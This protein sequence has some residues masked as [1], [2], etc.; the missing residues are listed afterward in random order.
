MTVRKLEAGA[1][2]LEALV[3]LDR[4]LPKVLAKEALDQMLQAEIAEFPGR[5]PASAARSAAAIGRAIAAAD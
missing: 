1:T 2:R 5:L 4:D 3:V